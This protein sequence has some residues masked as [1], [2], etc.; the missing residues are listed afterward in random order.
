MKSVRK[1]IVCLLALVMLISCCACGAKE[2][3]APT[4]GDKTP[5]GTTAQDNTPANNPETTSYPVIRLMQHRFT[6]ADCADELE[7]EE[8][9]NQ[10]F[11][12]K[13]GCE[14]DI[15][16]LNFGD[17]PD[18]LN[19]LLTGGKESLDI[20]SSLTFSSTSVMAANGQILDITPYMDN[21]LKETKELFV[22]YPGVL[23]SVQ[24]GGKQ[25]GLPTLTGWTS[26]NIYGVKKSY[27][28]AAGVDITKITSMDELTEAMIKMKEANPDAYFI[29]ASTHQY[30]WPKGMDYLGDQS[31]LGVLTDPANST[32]IENYYE[33]DL[34]LNHLEN[35]KVWMEK[36]II[37]PDGMSNGL[38]AG[39]FMAVQNGL[40]VG[41]T[42]YA[43]D[44]EE[45]LFEVN[46]QHTYGDEEIVGCYLNDRFLAT[47][48]VTT[49]MWHVT[50]FCQYPSEACKLLNELYTNPEASM[51][52]INGLEGKHYALDENGQITFPE[53]VDSTNSGWYSG[54]G[55]MYEPNAMIL[56]TWNYQLA[57]LNDRYIDGNNNSILSK[58]LGFTADVEEVADQVGAC[59]NVINQYYLPLING[60]VDID[61]V[62]P[63]FQAALKAAG[64]DDIIA[65]KQAQLDAWL[66]ANGK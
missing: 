33:S 40:T 27:A 61:E 56:P 66:A 39:A 37:L 8:A 24:V 64:I 26:P 32:T 14:V 16:F 58:A 20:F 62:L 18:K 55:G 15:I 46:S 45:W 29:P 54:F 60:C 11:R 44:L 52:L 4:S 10:I 13:C 47:G 49:Y 28:D 21:E 57:D 41:S 9:L 48:N 25:Y 63:Q 6:P 3:P 12:E 30:W 51:I 35:V 59:Q 22:N 36:E 38:D 5:E 65:C 2:T 31:Y 43:Q 42:G 7:I 23:E 50:P 34:F 1:L 17:V 19:L 53:G